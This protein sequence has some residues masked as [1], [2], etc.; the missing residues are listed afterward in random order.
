MVFEVLVEGWQFDYV[1]FVCGFVVFVG[2]GQGFVF[3]GLFGQVYF[4]VG[5]YQCVMFVVYIFFGWDEFQ[6]YL[7]VFFVVDF[8]YYVIDVLVDYI[9]Q[10]IG[11]VLVDIDDVVIWF[12]C[13]V[14]CSWIVGNDF[15]D[16]YYVVLVLQLC[17]DVFQ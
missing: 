6:V 4:L 1:D 17:V 8:G 13:V 2:N 9:F 14:Y 7:C 15:V 10:W 16:Y 12:E 11:F 5:Q 3:G